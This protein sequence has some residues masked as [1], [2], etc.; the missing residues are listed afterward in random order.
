MQIDDSD[1]QDA[2]ACWSRS[3]SREPLS[4][5]TEDSFPHSWK[6]SWQITSTEDGIQTDNS[7]KQP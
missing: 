6:Q 1:E 4:N 2:N 5:V 7:E 3:E